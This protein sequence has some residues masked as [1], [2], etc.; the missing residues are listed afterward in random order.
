[1][2]TC[3]A[4]PPSSAA[5]IP[6]F[7]KEQVKRPVLNGRPFRNFGP[8]IGLFHP[9]FNSFH[10]ALRDPN[11]SYEKTKTHSS[12]RALFEAFSNIYDT[13]EARIAAIDK[14]LVSLLGNSFL[15]IVVSGV[16]S[17]GVIVEGCGAFNA[18]VAI[19]EVKNEIGT[20]FTDPYNQASLSYRKYW[21]NSARELDECVF[22]I[23]A[24]LICLSARGRHQS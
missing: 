10:A 11:L 21:A 7:L 23:H 16:K 13:K 22:R 18:Y 19:R 5:V 9:V 8:P 12:I 17:D 14:P 3:N 6:V 2:T 4:L 1:L 20:A 24:L 15:P